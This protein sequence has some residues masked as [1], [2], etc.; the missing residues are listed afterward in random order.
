MSNTQ[1]N[2]RLGDSALKTHCNRLIPHYLFHPHKS[3]ETISNQI[4]FPLLHD[5]SN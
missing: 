3:G 1:I 4:A 2:M 5:V